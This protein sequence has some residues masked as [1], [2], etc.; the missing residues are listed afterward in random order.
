MDLP[1]GNPAYIAS[2][3]NHAKKWG[4]DPLLVCAVCEQESDWNPYAIRY[5][6]LFYSHYI[7]PLVNS[8]AVHNLTEA[9]ARA[10]SWGMM[11]IMGQVAREMGFVGGSLAALCDV[12]TG[13]DWGCEKL[14]KCLDA[15]D[16]NVVMALLRYNGGGNPNY[17]YEVKARM[18]K[19]Q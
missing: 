7:Q 3:K 2:A 13:L 18:G 10:T 1:I 17:P 15:A 8:G 9:T 16:G 12:D 11:Q 4:I 6:P 5:E 14:K 19:Y